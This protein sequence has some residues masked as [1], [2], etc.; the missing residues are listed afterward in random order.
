MFVVVV[1]V[2]VVFTFDNSDSGQNTKRVQE[3]KFIGVKTEVKPA[4]E[5]L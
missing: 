1:V 4:L 2:V 5:L 3:Q